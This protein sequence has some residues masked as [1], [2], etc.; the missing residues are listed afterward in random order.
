[1]LAILCGRQGASSGEM[2]DSYRLPETF[3]TENYHLRRLRVEDAPAI[4][5]AYAAD[6]AVTKYLTWKPSR[7]VPETAA[8]FQALSG[9]WDR[10]ESFPMVA[11]HQELSYSPSFG[12]DLA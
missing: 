8:A 6:P 3:E 12:Q 2:T 10:D 11:F 9:N 4:F 5:D 7:T 1:M